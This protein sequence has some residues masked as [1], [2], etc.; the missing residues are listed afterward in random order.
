M[1]K[2]KISKAMVAAILV[3]SVIGNSGK[4]VEASQK[5]HLFNAYNFN[6]ITKANAADNKDEL[7]VRESVEEIKAK[8][9]YRAKE[10]Y[11]D[12]KFK[13]KRVLRQPK[14]GERKVRKTYKIVDGKEVLI[15]TDVL[16]ETEPVNGITEVG[17][18]N[19]FHSEDPFNIILQKDSSLKNNEFKTEIMGNPG[20][21]SGS[22]THDVD[23][24]T[25][26]MDKIG[27][28]GSGGMR[29]QNQVI[30]F[31]SAFT[32]D[33][34]L[35]FSCEKGKG[36]FLSKDVKK[37][38]AGTRYVE[39]PTIPHS[40]KVNGLEYNGAKI[41]QKGIDGDASQKIIYKRLNE[42][43][44]YSNYTIEFKN[45]YTGNG[46][47][48]IIAVNPY[49]VQAL[50]GTSLVYNLARDNSI[51]YGSFKLEK[52]AKAGA[53]F[54][55]YRRNIEKT[56]DLK[57]KS[58][59][60]KNEK[61]L[62]KYDWYNKEIKANEPA[63]GIIKINTKYELP[64]KARI[65]SVINNPS[66]NKGSFKTKSTPIK[67]KINYIP[68]SNL[69]FEEKKVIKAPVDGLAHEDVS[70]SLK[71]Y[72]A[73]SMKLSVNEV[74]DKNKV[75]GTTEVGN[76]KVITEKIPYKTIKK[77]TKELKEGETKIQTKGQNGSKI[78]TTLYD[79]DKTTGKL[80]NPK[81]ST[82]TNE[83]VNEVVLVG[84]K[85][86]IDAG[87]IEDIATKITKE[88]EIIKA[89]TNYEADKSLEFG[90]KK[91]VTEP[92]DGEKEIITTS[93]IVNGKRVNDKKENVI[94]EAK[95]GLVKIGNKK[96]E[97]KE[98]QTDNGI[99]GIETTITIYDIDKTTGKLINP[100]ISESKKTFPM[101]EIED[102]AKGEKKNTVDVNYETAYIA[103]DSLEFGKTK[104]TQEGKNGKKEIINTSEIIN[105]K[106]VEKTTENIIEKPITKVVAV[107]N[108]K[109]REEKIP[110][111][112]KE[113][114]TDK[115]LVGEKKIKSA[116][117]DGLKVIDTIYE[118]N[119]E[120]GELSNEKDT[121]SKTVNPVDEIILVGTKKED[122]NFETV[123]KT[124][125]VEGQT[126]YIA[127]ENID[128]KSKNKTQEKSNGKAEVTYKVYEKDGK[129]VEEEIERKVIEESK[130]EIIEIGNKEISKK[131][132]TDKDGKKKIEVTTKI[133]EI[134]PDTGELSNPKEEI[135]YED[136]KDGKTLEE[137]LKEF[138]EQNK[139]K[140][141]DK[142]D[143]DKKEN[144]DNKEKT[145][146]NKSTE[147]EKLEENKNKEFDDK[148]NKEKEKEKESNGT[149]TKVEEN[150]NTNGSN[151]DK[152]ESKVIGNNISTEGKDNSIS[153]SGKGTILPK[154]GQGWA[155]LISALG[156]VSA[157]GF[158]LFKSKKNKENK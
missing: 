118:V 136:K 122:P 112:T 5:A 146:E 127:N 20:I 88:K 74:I 141:N 55:V 38:K 135:S 47:D 70:Y 108:K 8:M 75:D 48:R 44:K 120:T 147:N 56:Q 39:D 111:E 63:S 67:A 105:G 148:D 34:D 115:L 80:T 29:E 86:V 98:I 30:K 4:N 79:V 157:G 66:D 109:T 152:T 158:G 81:S 72:E 82:K 100:T 99:K 25:G 14:N 139:N 149:L 59:E 132:I 61:E 103:D 45:Q 116:G 43:D 97:E 62:E 126:K 90:T 35:S 76:K 50:S 142:N 41:L 155:G 23:P 143:N 68:N 10:T 96:I 42:N 145:D 138:E 1:K 65:M 154:T 36:S 69:K 19:S 110:F 3:S 106:R 9:T 12:L 95:D 104:V 124:E 13:E 102:I 37:V 144:V 77:E 73:F 85:K 140:D 52:D 64:E 28:G 26:E 101:E 16:S 71:A 54:R 89:K 57:S 87:K 46:K 107:G 129:K 91:V 131:I 78:T 117:K 114:K 21:T 153:S 83:A 32:Y 27:K 15:K 31:N 2:T 150:N 49:W 58:V 7:I 156:A 123:T 22:S 40:S 113:E 24:N 94:K 151:N 119:P 33:N 6:L 60:V 128:F 11:K 125:D 137:Q 134:N 51:P 93:K 17:N 84:T 53:A 121:I 18:V 130:D 92:V 133:Y